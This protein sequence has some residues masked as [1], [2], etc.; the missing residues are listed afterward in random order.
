M[1]L[2]HGTSYKHLNAIMAG[3]LRPRRR[4]KG[5]WKEYPSHPDMVYLTDAF[6]PYFAGAAST[7]KQLI[8]EVDIEHLH[9]MDLYP[10]EDLI[11]QSLVHNERMG[12]KDAQRHAIENIE[13]WQEHWELAMVH[14]G[15][16]A[17]MGVIPPEAF[18]RYVVV[19]T[20]A[21]PGLGMLMDPSGVSPII[22]RA[23][24]EDYR[25]TQR[26]LFDGGELPMVNRMRQLVEHGV[27]AQ[28]LLDRAV[29]ASNNRAGIEVVELQH[30]AQAQSKS[31]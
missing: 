6:A 30:P 28:E 14:M 25:A 7:S 24:A 2:C 21:N 31:S 15:T 3:G 27:E 9:E 22:Y 10:D 4:R 13:C 23:M 1:K 19:D 12:L 17:H 11:A 16:V 20:D 29:H 26:W 18:T 5:N 8:I